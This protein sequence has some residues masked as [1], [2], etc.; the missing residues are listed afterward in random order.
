MLKNI[1]FYGIVIG[2][3]L[4]MAA[5][6]FLS[7]TT[8]A[9]VHNTG[10]T[11]TAYSLVI[12]SGSAYERTVD[13]VVKAGSYAPMSFTPQTTGPLTITCKKDGHWR[14]FDL[15][16]ASPK[17]FFASFVTLQSCEHVVSKTVVTF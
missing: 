15:G 1:I 10:D 6:F 17:S 16:Q 4:V 11:D 7:V 8:L 14:G 13:K 9:L 2:A 12:I 5:Y 3:P